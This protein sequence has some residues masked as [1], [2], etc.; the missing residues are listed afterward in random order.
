MSYYTTVSFKKILSENI[1]DFLGEFKKAVISNLNEVAKVSWS[2]SPISDKKYPVFEKLQEMDVNVRQN[3]L[4][5]CEPWIS[6][7]FR[8]RV[9]YIKKYQMLAMFGIPSCLAKMFDG[10]VSFQNSTD[11]DY[12]REEWDDIKDFEDIYDEYQNMSISDF[13]K[14]FE[15]IKET[16]LTRYLDVNDVSEIS[17]NE[18]NYTKRS[19]T[20]AKIWNLISG[21]FE[22]DDSAC[23]ISLFS[24]Y[25][26]ETVTLFT[27]CCYKHYAN[28]HQKGLKT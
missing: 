25:D 23:Y 6:K 11:Q 26:R 2:H 5:D 9:T 1:F 24:F 4:D 7:V 12:K 10:T 22:D 16:P 13:S 8:Y 28:F 27:Y 20:Y 18:L 17:E 3:M 19:L 21:V 14:A 15:S